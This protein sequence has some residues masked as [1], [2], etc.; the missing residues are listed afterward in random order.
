MDGENR[1]Y[2]SEIDTFLFILPTGSTKPVCLMCS[3]TVALIKSTN[4]KHHETK[5]KCFEHTDPP[6]LWL[7]MVPETTL[8]GLKKVA[9]F[10]LTM[11]GS[12]AAFSTRNIIKTKYCSRLTNEHVHT[13]D[14][15]Q[16]QV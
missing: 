8:S 5:R 4:V 12:E 2:K 13:C 3:K 15:N 6:T 9:I 14:S 7:Q 16:A 1:V 11:F 10:I